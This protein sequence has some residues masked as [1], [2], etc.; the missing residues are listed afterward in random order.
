MKRFT[1]EATAPESLQPDEILRAISPLGVEG[2]ITE[3][4]PESANNGQMNF[5]WEPRPSLPPET[6]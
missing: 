2:R 6:P 3:T 5:E 1:I 4:A